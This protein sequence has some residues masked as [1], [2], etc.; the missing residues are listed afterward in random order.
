MNV[1]YL[2]RPLEISSR[3]CTISDTLSHLSSH[4]EPPRLLHWATLPPHIEPSLLPHRA[5]S[6]RTLSHPAFPHWAISPPTLSHFASDIEPPRLPTLSHLSSY[7]EPPR[8]SNWATSPPTL[9]HFASQIEPPLLLQHRATS[10][11]KLSHLASHTLILPASLNEPP[12]LR[13][14]ATASHIEPPRLPLCATPP[15]TSSH[16]ASLYCAATP[17]TISLP[18]HWASQPPTLSHFASDIESNIS[19]AWIPEKFKH[20][21]IPCG[22]DFSL[23]KTGQSWS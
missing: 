5:T 17:L 12:R 8:L 13:Q 16:L 3:Y 21:R 4:I 9:S 10:P 1:L 14:R 23:L 22:W 18:I 7:I 11:L 19:G 20:I 2:C 6:P 15:S